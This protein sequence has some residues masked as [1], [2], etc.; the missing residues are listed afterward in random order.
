[1]AEDQHPV[2][3][4]PERRPPGQTARIVVGVVL[5]AAAVAVIVDNRRDTRIGYVF[6]DVTA[7][8][9]LVLIVTAVVGAAI[10]W[11]LLHRPRRRD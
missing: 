10:G 7:P 9:I 11:L 3:R 6:G 4:S 2:V 8:L 1:M 5:L